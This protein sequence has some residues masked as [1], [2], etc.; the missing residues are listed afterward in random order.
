VR[1]RETEIYDVKNEGNIRQD[2]RIKLLK[3]LKLS[4]WMIRSTFRA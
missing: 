1:Q 3:S 2:L 4:F